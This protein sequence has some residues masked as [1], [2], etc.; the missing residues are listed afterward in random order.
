MTTG[1]IL[2]VED[3]NDESLVFEKI[4]TA[5]NY[6]VTVVNS[7]ED[8]QSLISEEDV[9]ILLLDLRLRDNDGMCLLEWIQKNKNISTPA[10]I[11]MTAFGE[12]KDHIAA[13][14]QGAI[15]VL[16]KPIDIAELKAKIAI[17]IQIINLRKTLSKKNTELKE[18]KKKLEQV[19]N[20]RKQF[21]TLITHDLRTPITTIKLAA[22]VLREKISDNCS[23][24]DKKVSSLLNMLLRNVVRVESNFNEIM[25]I[26][27]VE[28]GDL[29]LI[30]SKIDINSILT[31]AVNICNPEIIN[32]EI[33]ITYKLDNI[34]KIY[35]DECKIK[36]MVINMITTAM[37]RMDISDKIIVTT[38]KSG[39]NIKITITDTG[40]FLDE[41]Y[42]KT[43][44]HG[45]HTNLPTSQ[46]RVGFYT[47]NQIA[48]SHNGSFTV[49]SD[50]EKG[51]SQI[52]TI[53]ILKEP[54]KK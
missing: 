32:K 28:V 5:E 18:T 14:E 27:N 42:V 6:T 54:I 15:D 3:S 4:L 41:K 9:D 44:L 35:G 23:E 11:V 21:L 49:T 25:V 29:K 53:P 36:Q 20:L 47:A 12:H 46:T 34:P 37:S 1:K 38:K 48:N 26:A 40:P 19:I 50:L 52:A 17:H 22:E 30:Y 10:T 24:I 16:R 51:T 45:I 2:I 7:V 39:N 31:D 33:N 13:I 43:M 8:A